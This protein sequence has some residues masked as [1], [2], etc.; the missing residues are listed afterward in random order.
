MSIEVLGPCNPREK[1]TRPDA[2][3]MLIFIALKTDGRDESRNWKQVL[4]IPTATPVLLP[5]MAL[6]SMRD[7]CKA[8]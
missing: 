4:Q 5:R 1:D 7:A 2:T 6:A 8:A 3:E